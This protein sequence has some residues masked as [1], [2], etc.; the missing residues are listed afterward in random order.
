LVNVV[1]SGP[2][3]LVGAGAGHATYVYNA[4]NAQWALHDHLQGG[5]AGS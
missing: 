3:P 2:T 4:G 5:R 1:T